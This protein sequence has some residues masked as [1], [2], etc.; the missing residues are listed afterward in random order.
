MPNILQTFQF[1][2]SSADVK[3]AMKSGKIASLLG[4]EGS[5]FLPFSI[6]GLDTPRR[7][8]H[9]IGH[10]LAVLRQYYAL[11]VRYM[12]LTHVCHN[13]FADSCGLFKPI[14]PL[15]N[16]LRCALPTNKGYV[17]AIDTLPPF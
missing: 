6:C 10:S 12:T 14:A 15:H 2:T 1:A 4:V 7:S 11:G 5:V 9:Q 8:A 17:L 3:A 16:G 13:A